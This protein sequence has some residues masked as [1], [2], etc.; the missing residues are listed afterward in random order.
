MDMEKNFTSTMDREKNEPINFG[1]S[2]THEIIRS[3]NPSIKAT[4]FWSRNV[5]KGSLEWDIMLGQVARYR[6]QGRPWML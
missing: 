4:L 5:A 6:R 1:R 3:S 2:E